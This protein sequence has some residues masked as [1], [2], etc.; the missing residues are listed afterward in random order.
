MAAVTEVDVA[1][2]LA[3]LDKSGKSVD[4][5]DFVN[6]VDPLACNW[7]MTV[8][9]KGAKLPEKMYT[10]HLWGATV[11]QLADFIRGGYQDVVV[12]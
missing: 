4:P 7:V 9:H 8:Y 5:F 10:T 6:I 1:A 11:N 3:F 2:V 12:E